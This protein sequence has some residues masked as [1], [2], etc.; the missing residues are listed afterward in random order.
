MWAAFENLYNTFVPLWQAKVTLHGNSIRTYDL[1]VN[2]FQEFLGI[3]Q[4]VNPAWTELFREGIK[5]GHI[6]AMPVALRPSV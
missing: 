1:F 2:S 6:K 5:A 3:P 4:G